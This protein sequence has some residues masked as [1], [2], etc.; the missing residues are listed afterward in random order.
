MSQKWQDAKA[1]DEKHLRGALLPLRWV[2]CFM[3]SWALVAVI[4]V[5]LL[6]AVGAVAAKIGETEMSVRALLG[7][8]VFQGGLWFLIVA[9]LVATRRRVEFTRRNVGT[10]SIVT[11]LVLVSL[12]CL[13]YGRHLKHGDLMLESS[14][15]S[16]AMGGAFSEIGPPVLSFFDAERVALYLHHGQGWESRS[17]DGLP[18]GGNYNLGATGDGASTMAALG[19]LDAAETSRPALDIEIK[20]LELLAGRTQRVDPQI[21]VRV[22]GYSAR[23]EERADWIRVD[24]SAGVAN[25]QP[26]QPLRF[27]TL[28]GPTDL[29]EGGAISDKPG[30]V[31]VM[32][33]TLAKERHGPLA[34]DIVNV[35]YTLGAAS[36]SQGGMDERRWRDLSERLPLGA[37][38]GLVIE[39]PGGAGEPSYRHAFGAIVGDVFVAGQS[40]YRVE[41]KEL[42]KRVKKPIVAPGYLG[43]ESSEAVLRIVKPDGTAVERRVYHR[44]PEISHDWSTTEATPQGMPVG[45]ELDR[46]VRVSLIDCAAM[47]VYLDES[48]ETGRVRAIVR[49]PA[50][51]VRVIEDV[52]HGRLDLGPQLQV[53]IGERWEDSLAITRPV[54]IAGAADP[55]ESLRERSMLAVEV[56]HGAKPGWSRVVWLPFEMYFEDREPGQT[57]GGRERS[58][59]LPDGTRV[60]LGYGRQ[61]W[62]LPDMALQLAGFKMVGFDERGEPK[63]VEVKVSVTPRR[64]ATFSVFEQVVT[65]ER[66]MTVPF[67]WNGTRGWLGNVMGKVDAGWSPAQFTLR[68]RDWDVAGWKRTQSLVDAGRLSTAQVGFV[69]LEVV[70]RPGVWLMQAGASLLAIGVIWRLV[71][72]RWTAGRA[73]GPSGAV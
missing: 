31:A 54:P 28:H 68:V 60:W 4:A 16:H 33:P 6:G 26:P 39:A 10:L 73:S 62:A 66:S 58:V 51:D 20:P 48:I 32:R 3:S 46:N 42:N 12:G 57:P 67:E 5:A 69:T 63:R 72:W 9:A 11:G 27:V 44:Y 41:V 19:G 71:V 61:R 25:A 23:A 43:C 17:V 50:G 2:L 29:K 35:E 15:P 34:T 64:R 38:W 22:V 18:K 70:N 36:E 53:R 8:G 7:S 49:Q 14:A 30:A 55:H 56:T 1:W 13:H 21:K 37:E 47:Q 65:E 59:D 40:G 45:V 24:R 52:T